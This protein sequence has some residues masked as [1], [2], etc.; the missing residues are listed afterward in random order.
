M[1]TTSP[2]D[3]WTHLY[4]TTLPALARSKS[5]SQPDWPVHLDHCFARIILDAVIGNSTSTRLGETP[6]PWTA[7]LKSP[8]VKHMSKSQLDECI[9]LGEGIASGKANLVQLDEKSL[10]V[11]GKTKGGKRKRED[12]SSSGPRD[13][14]AKKKTS[15]RPPKAHQPDIRT[16]MGAA[17]AKSTPPSDV[18]ADLASKINLHPNLTPFRQRVLLALCQVPPGHYTTYLALSNYLHSS[19]RAVGN[20]LRNNP[21]APRVPCHRVV[22]SDG[23]IGGFGGEWGLKGKFYG[24]K[25]RLLRGEG[26]GVD[27]GGGRVVGRVWEMFR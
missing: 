23:G 19:P 14:S 9:S 13:L 1:T 10:A 12:S 27:E 16:L 20:A 4:T 22:A 7:K 2:I 6:T 5:P 26:V 17:L 11:R 3:R 25:V 15:A 21:F 8:A 18:P 24:E